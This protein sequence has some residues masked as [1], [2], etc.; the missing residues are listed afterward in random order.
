MIRDY[1]TVEGHGTTLL[2]TIIV[3]INNVSD[4]LGHGNIQV[5]IITLQNKKAP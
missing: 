3:I 4:Y 5:G 2:L 1:Q